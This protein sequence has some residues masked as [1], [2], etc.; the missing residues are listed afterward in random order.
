MKSRQQRL[1]AIELSLTPQQIV[2]VWLRGAVRAGTL[3][4][5]AVHVTLLALVI[6]GADPAPAPGGESR[7]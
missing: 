7:F 1:R 6:V 5:G 3:E 4:E 2:V